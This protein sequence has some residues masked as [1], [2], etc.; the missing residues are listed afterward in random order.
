MS[1]PPAC[2]GVNIISFLYWFRLPF[3]NL[4]IVC[5]I[6]LVIL[7]LGRGSI[8]A[9]WVILDSRQALV[10]LIFAVVDSFVEDHIPISVLMD[11]MAF[12]QL[13]SRLSRF[14]FK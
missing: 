8:V 7:G 14:P 5:S 13:M 2:V 4:K 9:M 6:S 10:M 3:I 1:S 12:S 11:L